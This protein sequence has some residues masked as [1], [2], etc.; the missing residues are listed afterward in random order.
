MCAHP[1]T[2]VTRTDVFRR[3][4]TRRVR[5]LLLLA[6][7]VALVWVVLTL[8]HEFADI[9]VMPRGGLFQFPEIQFDRAGELAP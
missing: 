8:A 1:H 3:A 2:A 6:A 4:Y 5:T 9:D 7:A